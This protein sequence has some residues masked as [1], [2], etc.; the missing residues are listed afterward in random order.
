MRNSRVENGHFRQIGP[1]E[2]GYFTILTSRTGARLASQNSAGSLGVVFTCL[3]PR[4]HADTV[5][6]GQGHGRQQ[7]AGSRKN[8]KHKGR[9]TG[10]SLAMD[11]LFRRATALVALFFLASNMIEGSPTPQR[12]G[13]VDKPDDS[14]LSSLLNRGM[15]ATEE[16]KPC[17]G[18]LCL[19]L[20]RSSRPA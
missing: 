1:F 4:P 18:R 6:S 15:A 16:R 12:R 5:V 8:R 19:Q 11:H 7:V 10:P 17:R 13:S 14:S 20:P 9:D 2:G 3:A